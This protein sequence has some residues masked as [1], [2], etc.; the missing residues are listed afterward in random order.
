[1]AVSTLI[2]PFSPAMSGAGGAVNSQRPWALALPSIG[3]DVL[4]CVR[5]RVGLSEHVCT[6]LRR[7]FDHEQVYDSFVKG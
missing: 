7:L 5:P 6:T 2:E 1:M 4:F 3:S